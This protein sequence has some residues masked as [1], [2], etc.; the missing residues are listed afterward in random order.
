M[1]KKNCRNG[2]IKSLKIIDIKNKIQNVGSN[3]SYKFIT[4]F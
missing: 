4:I 2:N 3:K 1:N